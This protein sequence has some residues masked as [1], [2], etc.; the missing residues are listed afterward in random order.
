MNLPPNATICPN[1]VSVLRYQT[2]TGGFRKTA[3]YLRL[4]E[5][6]IRKVLGEYPHLKGAKT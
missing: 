4:S 5:D 6:Y 1:F 3:G 2:R